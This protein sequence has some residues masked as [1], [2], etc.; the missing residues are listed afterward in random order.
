MS[1]GDGARLWVRVFVPAP[2][3][4]KLRV[5]QAATVLVPGDTGKGVVGKITAIA[6]RGEFTPRVALTEKERADL[7]FGVK[8]GISDPSAMV[9]AGLP[10][11]VT[12]AA[13]D[14]RKGSE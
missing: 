11:A 1:L 10:V 14:A 5:G 4:T 12:F 7:L 2:E 3:L 8:V 13:V 6:T 9:K